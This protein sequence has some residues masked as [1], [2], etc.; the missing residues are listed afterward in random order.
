MGNNGEQLHTPILLPSSFPPAEGLRGG[1]AEDLT[2]NTRA[3]EELGA[4]PSPQAHRLGGKRS[5]VFA[6]L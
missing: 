3:A 5:A 6:I 2:G 4:T 1:T